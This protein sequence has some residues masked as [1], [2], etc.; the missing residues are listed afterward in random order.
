MATMVTMYDD[1]NV[2]ALPPGAAAYAGY[3]DGAWANYGAIKA[4]FPH[5]KVLSIAVFP[6]A[7]AECLD[8]EAGDATVSQIYGWFKRQQ[9]AKVWKPVIYSSVSNISSIAATMNANGFARSSYRLW[10][11]HYS[12]THICGPSTC[13][14]TSAS[15]DATQWT[16]HALGRSLDE[17][18]CSPGFFGGTT[19]PPPPPPPSDWTAQMIA[20]LPTLQAGMQDTAGSGRKVVRLQG[21]LCALGPAVTIDGVFGPGTESA[22]KNQQAAFGLTQDGIVGQ[23]TWTALVAG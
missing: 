17:S 22:V 11:A 3:V 18:E 12:Y 10:S 23:A 6:S 9:A 19:P 8:V 4:R 5:A 7:D 13:R 20:N 14:L 15:C 21:L 1:V 2:S 16:D